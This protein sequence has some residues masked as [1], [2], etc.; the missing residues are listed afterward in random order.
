MA[1]ICG[2]TGIPVG[3]ETCKLCVSHGCEGYKQAIKQNKQR[4]NLQKK[5]CA[6]IIET[7]KETII[8]WI[9]LILI[10]ASVVVLIGVPSLFLTY[11]GIGEWQ[12]I[13]CGLWLLFW[14]SLVI[15][16]GIRIGRKQER[17]KE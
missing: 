2:N 10:S 9:S 11:A 1:V 14:L 5:D 17:D 6:K 7:L 3:S 4:E 16:V 12:V 15:T 8:V 13:V